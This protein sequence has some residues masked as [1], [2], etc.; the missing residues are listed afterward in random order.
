MRCGLL[1]G[2]SQGHLWESKEY[3][4]TLSFRDS[5]FP[6]A[7]FFFL[8]LLRR[9]LCQGVHLALPL[10]AGPS[11]GDGDRPQLVPR[12]DELF[13]ERDER[14][15][16]LLVVD[17]Q[18]LDAQIPVDEALLYSSAVRAAHARARP[19]A[20]RSSLLPQLRRV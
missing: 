4:G 10:S 17:E 12:R 16:G 18:L 15:G 20:R 11:G 19:G 14:G 9:L 8:S 2:F 5:P 1:T 6:N 3:T 7:A 13:L